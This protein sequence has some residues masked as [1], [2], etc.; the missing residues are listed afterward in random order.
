M[1]FIFSTLAGCV[2]FSQ[3]AC[4]D[5][6]SFLGLQL[7]NEEHKFAGKYSTKGCYVYQGGTHA[8]IAFYG[9]EG[10]REEMMKNPDYPHYRP[11][12]YDCKTSSK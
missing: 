2:P 12:G 11:L 6:S 10:T 7:G 1:E 8:G 4:K 3:Q 9:V 5:A